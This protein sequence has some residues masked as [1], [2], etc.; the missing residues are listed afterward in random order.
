MVD[1]NPRSGRISFFNVI[2]WCAALAILIF[3]A[4]LLRQNQRL[5]LGL[6]GGEISE[7]RPL[8]HLAALAVDGKQQPILVGCATYTWKLSRLAFPPIIFKLAIQMAAA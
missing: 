8:R 5:K 3:N 6:I 1:Q 2:L 4:V 7:G